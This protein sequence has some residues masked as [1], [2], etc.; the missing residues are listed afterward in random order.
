MTD[1]WSFGWTQLLTIA[2]FLITIGIAYGGFRSFERWKREKI[3]ESKIAVALEALA[4]GYEAKYVFSAIRSPFIWSHEWEDMPKHPGELEETQR[5]RGPL[6]AIGNRLHRHGEFFERVFKLQP[7]FM[8]IYG[9]D[10][11]ETFMILHKARREVEVAV[12]M[13]MQDAIR[14]GDYSSRDTEDLYRKLKG[15]IAEGS[16]SGRGDEILERIQIFQRKIEQTCRPIIDRTYKNSE[17]SSH[18][19]KRFRRKGARTTEDK[20]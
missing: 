13:L 20:S 17:D 2:G 6:Y 1:P 10:T 3:E 16:H 8:A 18:W 19:S 12:D 11:E 14:P 5:R 15:H 4:L 9:R 7:R